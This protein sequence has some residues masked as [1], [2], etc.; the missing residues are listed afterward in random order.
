MTTQ[1]IHK[2]NKLI[3]IGTRDIN[4]ITTETIRITTKENTEISKNMDDK[5]KKEI[6]NSIDTFVSEIEW[7]GYLDAG[8]LKMSIERILGKACVFCGDKIEAKLNCDSYFVT[9][10]KDRCWLIY[11]L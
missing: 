11:K 2:N 7:K 1:I 9:C 5:T 4:R 8:I 10:Y 3:L 6:Y